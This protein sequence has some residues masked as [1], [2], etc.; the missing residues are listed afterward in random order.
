MLPN[1]HT[2]PSVFNAN[3]WS[4]PAATA[5][6]FDSPATARG[7]ELDALIAVN[8]WFASV[9]GRPLPSMVA[10]AGGWKA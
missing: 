3:A 8:V 6:T 4:S 2:V 10:K 1:D 5:A 7:V 9:L